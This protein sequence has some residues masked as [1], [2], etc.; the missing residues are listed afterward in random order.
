MRIRA[1]KVC[2]ASI[3]SSRH[4]GCQ[5]FDIPYMLSSFYYAEKMADWLIP[6]LKSAELLM[7]DSGAFS[8]MTGSGKADFDAYMTRYIDFV[9]KYDVEYFFELDID[10]IVGYER[11]KE[12][13][14][15]LEYETGRQCIP[16]WH[17]SRGTEEYVKL[18]RE[19]AYI[20]IGGIVTK[21][22]PQRDFMKL[23]KLI[24][25]AHKCKC[26][27]HGLGFTYLK[28]LPLIKFDSVDS[29]TWT[30]GRRYG[31]IYQFNGKT[32]VSHR[33]RDAR[34]ESYIEADLNNLR[35]WIKFQRYADIYF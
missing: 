18:C 5:L 30:S 13:R 7:L 32:L 34:V 16:V 14:K 11:V 29:S 20:A 22:I 1:M 8:F 17:V 12:M 25:I 26:K 27:V 6:V 35:E 24:D 21:E 28:Y 9:K 10:S 3:D 4:L 23:P 2:L 33:R 15:R 19:Y 31:T